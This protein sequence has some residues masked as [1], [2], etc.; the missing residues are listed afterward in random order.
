MRTRFVSTRWFAVVSLVVPMLVCSCGGPEEEPTLLDV[1][2]EGYDV[3][4]VADLSGMDAGAL[5]QRVRSM[6]LVPES[7][8]E[9]F[10]DYVGFDPL[11]WEGWLDFFSLDGAG[12]LGLVLEM[13][14]SEEPEVIALYLPTQALREVE[15]NMEQLLP[16]EL[17]LEVF[18]SGGHVVLAMGER[19]DDVEDF[20]DD[21]ESASRPLS[22]EPGYARFRGLAGMAGADL[23]IYGMPPASEGVSAF[24]LSAG[25]DGPAISYRMAADVTDPDFA[26]VAPF[27]ESPGSGGRLLVP[28]GTIAVARLCVDM[29]PIA[30]SVGSELPPEALMGLAMMG[31]ESLEDFVGLFRGDVCVSLTGMRDGV[32]SGCLAIG[33]NDEAA[34]EQ[35][36][37]TLSG[38]ASG[39]GAVELERFEFGGRFALAVDADG[40]QIQAGL[41]DGAL[42]LTVGGTLEDLESDGTDLPSLARDFGLD[43][44]DDGSAFILVGSGERLAGLTQDLEG[45]DVILGRIGA[46]E[47]SLGVSEGTLTHEATIVFS[48]DEDAWMSV[49]DILEDVMLAR[50]TGPW[51]EPVVDSDQDPSVDTGQKPEDETAAEKV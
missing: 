34:A 29:E 41:H 9:S 23:M 17:G 14:H 8:L 43:A 28:G 25:C 26:E 11:D 42:Y 21:V 51:Q 15:E 37:E 30:A 5:M 3:Y 4:V 32:P 33:L 48:G 36:L 49:F 22:E 1:M 35:L 38:L 39:A 7:D 6:N 2:P 10:E 40:L 44:V 27:L 19:D 12:E 47:A 46:F 18:Q 13:G 50:M 24:L 16:G 20:R 45:A 31:F